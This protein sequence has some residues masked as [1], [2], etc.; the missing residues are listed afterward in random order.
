MG[1][2]GSLKDVGECL[3]ILASQLC[4]MTNAVTYQI[5]K[6][7]EMQSQTY[8]YYFSVVGN[9][10]NE[11]VVV[12]EQVIVEPFGVGISLQDVNTATAD[13]KQ[14]PPHGQRCTAMD[15]H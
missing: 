12:A 14:W 5:D 13:Q 15:P 8:S 6:L 9:R 1:Q 4:G 2:L 3:V 7:R 10:S 11:P